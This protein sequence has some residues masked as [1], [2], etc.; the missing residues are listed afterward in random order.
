MQ[1][2]PEVLAGAR[3]AFEPVSTSQRAVNG[4]RTLRAAGVAGLGIALPDGVVTSDS[5]AE[6]LGVASG[7]IERRTGIASR[8]QADPSVRVCDLAAAAAAEAL[9]DAELDAAEVD[10]VLVAT[11]A[12]DEITPNAAPQVAHAIGTDHAGAVDIGAACTGFVSALTIAAG[13]IEA[14]RAS[15][16]LVVGAEVLSRYTNPDDRTTAGVF[17]D[18]AGAAVLVPRDRG[19]LGRAVLGSDGLAAP[20]IVAPRE[21]GFIEMD[22]HETFKRA[23]ATLA[24]NATQAVHANGLE[25]DDVA[26]FVL[27]QANGRI[28]TAVAETLG[29]APER[30]LNTIREVGNT[31]A[32]SVPLALYAAREQ[33]LLADGDRIVLGAVGA[34]F[35]WGALVLEWSAA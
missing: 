29:V 13:L 9:R 24:A 14:H 34:G 32:A 2:S 10:L 25:L 19:V 35:T 8:R 22:G 20:Y 16:V 23:V 15:T 4:L 1:P 18:G 26:L 7:W 12:A 11:V 6:R 17:G 27:H 33:G 30:V 31:S 3:A 21:G 5:I 28:L